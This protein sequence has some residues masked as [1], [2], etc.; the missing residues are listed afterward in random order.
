M[1]EPK[2]LQAIEFYAQGRKGTEIATE[3]GLCPE[4]LSRWRQDPKF[5][6]AIFNRSRELLKDA[7]PE[8][9][10]VLVEKAIAGS[11][12]HAKLIL[13]HLDNVEK[14]MIQSKEQTISFTWKLDDKTN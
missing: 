3:L 8:I 5:I 2:Q 14:N 7:L 1:F 9:Y 11:Y 6:E 12:A 4:T 13:E 10:K